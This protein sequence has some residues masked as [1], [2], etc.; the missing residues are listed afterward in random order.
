MS[1]LATAYGAV[2]TAPERTSSVSSLRWFLMS[3]IS[4]LGLEAPAFDALRLRS[5]ARPGSWA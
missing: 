4:R 5:D 3:R 2:A 1:W